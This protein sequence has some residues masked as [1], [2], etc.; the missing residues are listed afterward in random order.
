MVPEYLETGVY[1]PKA[2]VA[3]ISNAMDVGAPSNF[4]R[5]QEI[6][7][8]S[9]QEV[10]AVLSGYSFNDHQTR[11][12]LHAL[13]K[14]HG[15]IADPHGAIGY[16]ALKEYLK[17]HPEK[18]GVFMETAHPIKFMDVIPSEIA[19]N[20]PITDAI[21]D[22]RAKEKHSLPIDNYQDLKDYLLKA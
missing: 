2:S 9:Y 3:T 4:V 18:I 7:N 1:T 10:K 20:I 19:S 13:Y 22:L 12:A 8:N 17:V 16:L 21:K 11:E 6:Y 14:D 5:I 15:Y